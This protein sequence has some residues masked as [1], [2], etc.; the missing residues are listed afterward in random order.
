MR[1]PTASGGRRPLYSRL[2]QSFPGGRGCE[3][4]CCVPRWHDRRTSMSQCTG[5][6]LLRTL[7][8]AVDSAGEDVRVCAGE[9]SAGVPAGRAPAQCPGQ[10][11]VRRGI[12]LIVRGDSESAHR[13]RSIAV[14]AQRADG[15]GR[16]GS[17]GFSGALGAREVGPIR[18]RERPFGGPGPPALSLHRPAVCRPSS[19]GRKRPVPGVFLCGG[20]GRS[21]VTLQSLGRASMESVGVP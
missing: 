8:P 2:M 5:D 6:R 16:V 20:Q 21:A 18:P 4:P 7:A 17:A 9:R 15:E 1:C 12:P 14:C 11:E 10:F 3:P 19:G 13:C